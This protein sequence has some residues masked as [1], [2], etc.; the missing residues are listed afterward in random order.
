M[1]FSAATDHPTVRTLGIARTK[2][3]NGPWNIDPSPMLPPPEQI[4]NA[5][6][7]HDQDHG[8]WWVFTNHVGLRDGLEYTD[9]IWAYWTGDLNT[10]NPAHKAIV[11]DSSN[12]Q[13]SRHIVGLPSVVQVGQ[14]LALFY[15]GNAEDPMPRGVKSHMHRDVGLA[16]LELPL[17]P[18]PN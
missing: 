6:L 15:D 13:W 3:L 9:A 7:Y 4:E 11:L 14:R 1:V 12:C 5:S 18:P 8:R 10:W 2:D 16:W 17:V